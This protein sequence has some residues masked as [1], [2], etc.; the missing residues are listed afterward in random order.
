MDRC[1]VDVPVANDREDARF[2]RSRL[3]K[4]ADTTRYDPIDN[5]SQNRDSD[6]AAKESGQARIRPCHS[7]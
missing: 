1:L 6:S 2:K 5:R 4:R 3:R 7:F